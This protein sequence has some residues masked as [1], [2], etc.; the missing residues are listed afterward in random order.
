MVACCYWVDILTTSPNAH[1]NNL[2][3]MKKIDQRYQT[4]AEGVCRPPG[5]DTPQRLDKRRRERLTI[6]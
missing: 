5:H 4:V 3:R 6:K 2:M 1:R